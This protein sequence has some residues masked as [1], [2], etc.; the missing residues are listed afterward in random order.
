MILT[1]KTEPDSASFPELR[2]IPT[3]L[4]VS[5]DKRID[6]ITNLTGIIVTATVVNDNCG[7]RGDSS[8]SR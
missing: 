3:T 5:Q 4:S 2:G 8:L 1:I 7:S 6:D